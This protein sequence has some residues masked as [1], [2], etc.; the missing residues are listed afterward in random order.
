M[1]FKSWGQSKQLVSQDILSLCPLFLLLVG[2]PERRCT[3]FEEPRRPKWARSFYGIR[4]IDTCWI[5][6]VFL[7]INDKGQNPE[8]LPCTFFSSFFA[9]T[10]HSE[11][12]Q[13][14]CYPPCTC[15]ST[16]MNTAFDLGSSRGNIRCTSEAKVNWKVSPLFL[17]GVFLC[18][19]CHHIAS[20]LASLLALEEAAAAPV[21][22][23]PSPGM[24]LNRIVDGWMNGMTKA[25]KPQLMKGLLQ[26]KFTYCCVG[27]ASPALESL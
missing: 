23:T 7:K 5:V 13:Q 22:A 10:V 26:F 24:A 27:F 4:N 9:C 19:C 1:R 11:H 17:I 18:W 3:D 2:L 20:F 15:I 6:R 21:G 16:N 8:C 25:H 12:Y 14:L